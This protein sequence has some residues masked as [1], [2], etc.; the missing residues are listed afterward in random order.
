MKNHMHKP[1]MLEINSKDAFLK[2]MKNGARPAAAIQGLDLRGQTKA[3]KRTDFTGSIFLSCI[4]SPKGAKA[5]FKGGGLVIPDSPKFRFPAHRSELYS[6]EELFDGYELDD[7]SSYQGT[8]DYAIYAEYKAGGIMHV[9]LDIDLYRH[10]HDHSITN[11]LHDVLKDRKVVAIMGGHGMERSDPM[12]S[13]I[14]RLSRRLT[15]DGYLMVS[16]GGPGAMEATHL[17]AYFAAR[18]ETDLLRAIKIL[19]P[20]PKGAAPEKEYADLDWL[21]RA[22]R[23]RD[24]YPLAPKDKDTCMSIGIPT[25]FYGHEPPAAFATHIAKYFANSIREDGLLMIAHHGVIFAPGSAGTRQEIF[26]DAAQNHYRTAG[27]PSPMI[28][29]GSDYWTGKSDHRYSFPVWQLVTQTA[30]ED[31]RPLMHLTDEVDEI[32][33]IVKDFE[34][35]GSADCLSECP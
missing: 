1:A 14:A 23:V 30:S 25:W 29:L 21:Q 8:Y 10:L 26:Q 18:S 19:S 12:Y 16:G 11:A 4:L 5:I 31:Y 27:F 3:L 15:Q 35:S 9:P 13:Q 34:P 17:G 32:I 22:W 7:A 2:W 6:V 33:R 28:F 24:K 20:R